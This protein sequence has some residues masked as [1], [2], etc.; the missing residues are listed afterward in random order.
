M[1]VLHL[2][3]HNEDCGIAKYQEQYVD[4]FTRLGLGEHEF[5]L[6]SPNE[7]KVKSRNDRRKMLEEIITQAEDFDIVH[8]QHEFG[9]YSEDD[10]TYFVRSVKRKGKKVVVSVHTAPNVIMGKPRLGGF[11]PRSFAMYARELIKF[12]RFMRNHIEGF[13]Q[14]DI[15]L[16]HNNPT[17]SSL[18]SFGVKSEKISRIMHPVPMERKR[19]DSNFIRSQLKAKKEDFVFSIIG[20][21]HKNKGVEDAVRALR[22]LPDNYKLAVIGGLHPFSNEVR[23]YND[24]ADLV[25]KLNLRDRVFITGFIEN[26]DLLDGYIQ[27]SDACVYPYDKDYYASVSSGSLNLSF[28]NGVPAVA[29]PTTSFKEMVEV[30]DSINLTPTFA[31][32]ELAKTLKSLQ[33]GEGL[34]SDAK[35][36][37]KDYSWDRQAEKVFKVY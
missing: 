23:I 33:A 17:K 32:Y 19:H 22:Y 25:D 13:L 36:Y 30:Y 2:T 37:M 29:Y 27:E 15:L 3:T 28:A 20:F 16:V 7:I 11:G 5:S 35:K 10:F 31:Y 26:D 34:S 1:R 24:I 6:Y 18:E 21:L 12:R 8:I 14:S 9:F 4:S